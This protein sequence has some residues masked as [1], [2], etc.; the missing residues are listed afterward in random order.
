MSLPPVNGNRLPG[1][2]L[3]I[4]IAA[5]LVVRVALAPAYAY[6]PNNYLDESFWTS[7]MFAIHDHGVLNVFRTTEANYVGYQW[8]LWVLSLIYEAIGGAYRSGDA[9]LHLLVKAPSIAAD[10]A[11]I[12]VVYH[13]TAALAADPQSPSNQ[14]LD[15]NRRGVSR[16]ARLALA[17]AAVIAFQPAVIY[18]SAIWAQTDAAISVAMLGSMLLLS[19][20]RTNAA[21]TVWALGMAVKPQPVMILPLLAVYTLQNHGA[22]ALFRGG[23]AA[24]ATFGLVLTPWILHGDAGRLMQAYGA[25]FGSDYGRLSVSAWNTWWFV[26]HMT[27][28]R[29]SDAVVAILPFASYR[30]LGL[31]LSACAAV[32]AIGYTSVH[33]DLRGLLIAGAY[34]AFAFYML[35]MSIHERYLFPMLA[36]LLP[37]AVV[38]RRWMWVY[39]PASLTLFANMFVIAPPVHAWAGRWTDAPFIPL[40]TAANVALFLAYSAVVTRD[41]ARAMP[42]ARLFVRQSY[43]LSLIGRSREAPDTELPKAA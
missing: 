22:R 24:A 20:G 17:A 23:G 5:G 39:A 40:V 31:M 32:L 30:L 38:D 10:L 37:V 41:A 28:V 35:P 11:L 43:P 8:V 29:P 33:R 9:R 6:L 15:E 7:W 18:D 21:W 42:A 2:S 4:I 27:A 19:R 12:V 16:S 26:D 3:A 14:Q 34:L 25:L 36:V 1:V 13:A